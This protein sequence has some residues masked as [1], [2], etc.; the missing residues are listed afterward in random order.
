MPN[1][2]VTFRV[3]W[4]VV[5]IALV[6]DKTKSELPVLQERSLFTLQKRS[7]QIVLDDF[8]PK[9]NYLPSHNQRQNCSLFSLGV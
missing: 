8:L 5:A 4:C 3:P 2:L 9:W 6:I 7:K 1:S